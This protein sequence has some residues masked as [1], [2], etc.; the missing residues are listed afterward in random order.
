MTPGADD[1]SPHRF[2]TETLPERDRV[3]IWRD[4]FGRR[5]L[6]AE[7]EIFQGARFYHTTTFRKLAG[8]SLGLSAAAGFRGTRARQLLGDGSD[9]LLL[10]INLEG[11]DCL[12]QLG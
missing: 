8:L 11:T 1:F 9:D 12:W 10:T 4:V 5:M 6:K 7:F 2:S 3:A